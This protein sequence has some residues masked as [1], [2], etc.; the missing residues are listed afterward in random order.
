MV[1]QQVRSCITSYQ[2]VAAQFLSGVDVPNATQLPGSCLGYE[3]KRAKSENQHCDKGWWKTGKLAQAV[4][5][6]K[7]GDPQLRTNER[8]RLSLSMIRRA[9]YGIGCAKLKMSSS[10]KYHIRR[11]NV[12]ANLPPLH[13]FHAFPRLSKTGLTAWPE[14]FRKL[15]PSSPSQECP[16]SAS[17]TGDVS[18]SLNPS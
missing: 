5:L 13:D 7:V 11:L 17:G 16:N 2:A 1:P 9:R 14:G 3:K 12:A 8:L 10:T 6:L 4:T 18:F 15:K